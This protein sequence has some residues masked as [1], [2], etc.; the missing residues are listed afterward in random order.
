M[1]NYGQDT[2]LAQQVPMPNMLS[3]IN[4]RYCYGSTLAAYSAVY[5]NAIRGLHQRHIHR[6]LVCKCM[7]TGM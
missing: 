3:W 2:L 1:C 6:F 4:Q 5:R 7:W